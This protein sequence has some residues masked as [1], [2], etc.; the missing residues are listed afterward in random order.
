[1]RPPFDK[2]LNYGHFGNRFDVNEKVLCIFKTNNYS[3]QVLFIHSTGE[4]T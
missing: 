2:R 4:T 3:R 1:M